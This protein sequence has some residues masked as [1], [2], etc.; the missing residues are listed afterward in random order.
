MRWMLFGA[1]SA[2][3]KS[4]GGGKSR[5]LRFSVSNGIRCLSSSNSIRL[6]ATM[7]SKIKGF[8]Y[9]PDKVELFTEISSASVPI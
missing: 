6:W 5:I 3:R 1:D 7:V 8:S 2:A 9:Y 4:R